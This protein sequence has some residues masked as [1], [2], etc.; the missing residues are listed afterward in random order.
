MSTLL[1]RTVEICNR[2]GLHARA[3]AALAREALKHDAT[4]TLKHE[5]VSADAASIMDLLMLTA[6]LGCE[7]TVIAEGPEAEQAMDGVCALISDRFG[8][9]E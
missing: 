1:T 4:V 8:E 3:S 6:H 9:G 7:V 2:R 5:D